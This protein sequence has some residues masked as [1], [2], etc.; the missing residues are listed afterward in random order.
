MLNIKKTV[1]L[2][3][4]LLWGADVFV[5]CWHNLLSGNHSNCKFIQNAAETEAKQT[6]EFEGWWALDRVQHIKFYV[7]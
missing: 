3:D 7:G 1:R 6:E 5:N 2:Q 4:G